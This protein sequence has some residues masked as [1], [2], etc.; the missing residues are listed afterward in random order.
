MEAKK[1]GMSLLTFLFFPII[2]ISFAYADVE[3]CPNRPDK[4]YRYSD[5]HEGLDYEWYINDKGETIFKEWLDVKILNMGSSPAYNV[6][7][8]V[9]CFPFY[10][11]IVDGEVFIGDIPAGGEAW[12]KDYFILEINLTKYQNE[13]NNPNE[14]IC[15]TIEYEDA[16]GSRYEL[17]NVAKFCGEDCSAICDL[18]AV[19]LDSFKADAG[20][21]SVTLNWV[22]GDE[23]NNFGFNIYRSES[24]DGEYT[25]INDTIIYSQMSSGLGA[26]YSFVDENIKNRKTYYYKLEDVDIS[27]LNTLHGPVIATPRLIYGIGK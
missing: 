10:D 23:T 8:V 16:A 4:P 27:G 1:C 6:K 7:A 11:N 19:L 13:S 15:W 22:T 25:R 26:A 14:G 18:T 17:K 20:N 12:S 2:F 24:K 5:Y 3:L 21:Q 9:S